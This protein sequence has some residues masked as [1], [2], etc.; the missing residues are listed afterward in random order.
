M[1]MDWFETFY[2]K[3]AYAI[4]SVCTHLLLV[5]EKLGQKMDFLTLVL[6]F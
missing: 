2:L 5:L 1:E 4:D 6:V 3:D